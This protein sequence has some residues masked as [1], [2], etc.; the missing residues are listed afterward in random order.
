MRSLGAAGASENAFRVAL[1][2]QGRSKLP[3][4]MPSVSLRSPKCTRRACSGAACA[5]ETA[6]WASP[7]AARSLEKLARGSSATAL[8]S[9]SCADH[10]ESGKG[11][12]LKVLLEIFV[13]KGCS[14]IAVRKY[15]SKIL[16]EVTCLCNAVLTPTS[17]SSACKVHGMH[18]ITLVYIYIY[19]YVHISHI[20]INPYQSISIHFHEKDNLT[21]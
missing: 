14:E 7:K 8:L 20:N 2:S 11:L 17:R 15:C 18:G 19:I 21:D 3:P 6:A 1:E 16:F 10:L 4:E 9:N 5:L 13:R 12:K